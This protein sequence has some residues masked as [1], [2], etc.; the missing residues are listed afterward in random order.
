L[1]LPKP[2]EKIT[3]EDLTEEFYKK[4]DVRDKATLYLYIKNVCP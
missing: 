1:E 3:K 2:V 4:I